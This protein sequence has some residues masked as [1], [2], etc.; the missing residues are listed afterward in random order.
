MNKPILVILA[1][2][3]G[4]RFGGLKQVAPIDGAGRA[5]IDYSIYDAKRAGFETAVCI[6]NPAQ[7]KD[8]RDMIGDRLSRLIDVRYAYQ[9]LDALPA[10]FSVPEGRIKPWGT[11]HAVLAAKTLISG[12]FAVVNADDFYGASSYKQMYNALQTGVDASHGVMVGFMLENTLTEH[13]YVSRGICEADE[14]GCLTTITERVHIERR[15]NGAMFLDEEGKEAFLPNG[16]IASMNLWGFDNSI[17]DEIEALFAS[18]LAKYLPVN[19]LK[20]EFYLPYVVDALLRGGGYDVKVE[21][22]KEKWLGVTYANDLPAVKAAIAQL[23]ADG[24]YPP[25]GLWGGRDG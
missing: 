20:C 23:I 22:T 9:H 6:I 19:P 3:I 16:T 4:S 5:I 15:P 18:F 21:L 2:G 13:G 1:A 14:S 8:F 7:E 10:G 12:P 25:A 24:V 11:A 17:I